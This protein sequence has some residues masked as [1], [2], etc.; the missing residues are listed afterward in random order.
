MLWVNNN[1]WIEI[2]EHAILLELIQELAIFFPKGQIGNILDFVGQNLSVTM[3]RLFHCSRR[4]AT[5]ST[6]TNSMAVLQ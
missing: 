6:Y 3:T 4:E 1:E 5:G 2:E